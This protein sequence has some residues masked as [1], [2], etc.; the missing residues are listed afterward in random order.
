MKLLSITFS[1][2]FIIV[3]DLQCQ[4]GGTVINSCTCMCTAGYTGTVCNS[5]IDYCEN[6]NC[7]LYGSCVNLPDMATHE[8]SCN[9]GWEG[10]T[11]SQCTISNCKECT[12]NPP[13]CVTCQENY[14]VSVSGQYTITLIIIIE[15]KGN[16]S[17]YRG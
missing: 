8:C 3:C 15:L 11:C 9:D 6:N 13:V 7:G 16:L 12:G 17:M 10:P 4:N 5:V 2:L 14:A 1:F